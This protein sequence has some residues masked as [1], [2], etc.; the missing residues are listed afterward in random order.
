MKRVFSVLII[1]VITLALSGPVSLALYRIREPYFRYPVDMGQKG[2]IIRNDGHGGGEFGSKRRNGRSHAGI[3]IQVPVGTPVRAA[4]SGIAFC[5]NVPTGYGKYVMIYHPDGCQT[6]YGHLSNWNVYSTQHVR[7]GEIIGF[8]GKTG[9]ANSK[10]IEP[11]LHFEIQKA[12]VA[13]DPRGMI[14]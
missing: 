13:Q 4:K 6:I 1:V 3:D 9:N 14:K 5:L 8:T 12:G 2:I 10:S 11:H 7:R